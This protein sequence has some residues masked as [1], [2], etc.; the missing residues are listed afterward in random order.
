MAANITVRDD[1]VLLVIDVQN[2]F[3]P[4]GSL[5]VTEGD[6]VVP[7][8]NRVAASFKHIVLTQDWH[9]PQHQSFASAHPGR[10]PFE[11]ATLSYGS[12]VLWPDHC[13]QGTRG[14]EFH[15]AL[16]TRGAELILR[17]GFRAAIDSYSAFRENDRTTLTGLAGYLRE[18]GLGRVFVAGLAL[19]YCVRYTAEDAVA[20][21]FAAIAIMDGC[22]G[23]DVGGSVAD[24]QRSFA[25]LGVVA[26]N[27]DTISSA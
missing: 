4:G 17:K 25:A 14:A 7:V 15:P 13:V 18:R 8:I 24:T 3:C 23:I 1:D 21:G 19:D 5:A 27:A 11:T 22:R 20:A 6:A 26:V 10:K 2:D 16:V 12:Q 9:S